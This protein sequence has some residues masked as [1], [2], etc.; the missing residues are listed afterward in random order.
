MRAMPDT[1]LI[2]IKMNMRSFFIS[3]NTENSLALP[4]PNKKRGIEIDL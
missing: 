1:L 2:T 4:L 3:F